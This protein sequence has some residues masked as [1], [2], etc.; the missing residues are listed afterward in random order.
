MSSA[1][2]ESAQTQD[3]AIL[4][5]VNTFS[6]STRT[7]GV[8]SLLYVESIAVYGVAHNQGAADTEKNSLNST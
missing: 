1:A 7:V 4:L 5:I 3:G 8:L 6:A 2:S